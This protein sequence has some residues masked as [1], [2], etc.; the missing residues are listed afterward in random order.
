MEKQNYKFDYSNLCIGPLVSIEF[1]QTIVTAFA[2][3]E[4]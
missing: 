3:N 1:N 2:V 4:K